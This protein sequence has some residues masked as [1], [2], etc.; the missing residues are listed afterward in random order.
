MRL[1][2]WDVTATTEFYRH[3][4]LPAEWVVIH[5]EYYGG[6][7]SNDLAVIRLKGYLDFAAK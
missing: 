1:G 4:E 7:L 5:P 6:D 2:D 3:V